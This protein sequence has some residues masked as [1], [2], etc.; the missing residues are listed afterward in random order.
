M[1]DKSF[2]EL[3]KQEIRVKIRQRQDQLREEYQRLKNEM[4]G[5]GLISPGILASGASKIM[6][7]YILDIASTSL[8]TLIRYAYT[9]PNLTYHENISGDLTTAFESFMPKDVQEV[10]NLFGRQSGN[11][12][13]DAHLRDKANRALEQGRTLAHSEIGRFVL[14]LEGQATAPTASVPFSVQNINSPGTVVQ[15]GDHATANVT[16][17]ITQS[18]Q[19]TIIKALDAVDAVITSPSASSIDEGIR[20]NTIELISTGRAEIANATPN[21]TTLKTVLMGLQNT[22]QGLAALEG[23]RQLINAALS[24]L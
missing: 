20:N 6:S 5:R 13:N 18:Q 7:Q 8:E 15:T 2:I 12:S 24:C 11:F 23:A 14:Y 9:A 16:Q 1:P 10:V 21:K 4:A 3:A 17:T 19:E 22:T